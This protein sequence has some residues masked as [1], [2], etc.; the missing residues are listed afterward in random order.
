MQAPMRITFIID[1]LAHDLGGTE[2]QLGKIIQ[3]LSGEFEINLISLRSS[4]WLETRGQEL[5]CRLNIFQIDN[6]KRLNTYRNFLRLIKH[7]RETKP[8]VVHTFFPVSNIMGVLAARL[9][10]VH[11]IAASRRDYGEWMSRRYLL[12]SRFANYFVDRIVTNS[13]RVKLLTEQREKY[14]ASKIL[15]IYNGLALEA[16]HNRTP[17]L[18]IRRALKIPDANKVI[19]L[20][21]NY[22]P[23]K[24]HETF[25]RAI[26]EIV[27]KRNDIDF[28]LIGC[29]SVPG[30]PQKAMEQL[31]VS[32][33]LSQCVH[34]VHADGN[35]QDYLS[36]LDV[37][38]N[39]SEGEG[40]SN[41]IME[42]MAAEV[43]C[44]VSDSGGNPDLITDGVNGCTFRL[45]DYHALAEKILYILKDDTS[46]QRF[47]QRARE[48]IHS[49]MSLPVMIGRFS[50]FYLS[51]KK[52]HAP[53]N[54]AQK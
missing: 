12:M 34:F 45:N 9:A 15:V 31:A 32:L 43:P 33:G 49:E 19:G 1:H 41:A 48:K 18:E 53:K 7:L 4:E 50:E 25:I 28:I 26:S 37:G 42:Y 54:E 14:P 27:K 30:E 22:R 20:V 36:I 24:R 5:G 21:A 40:L 10:G 51:L 8:D 3:G 35:V 29:D 52:N 6:F 38:V 17:R 47:T 2:N 16:F 46:R 39:C 44:V 13:D 23:M 11:A